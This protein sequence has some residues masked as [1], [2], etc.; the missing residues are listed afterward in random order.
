MEKRR[1]AFIGA[2]VAGVTSLIGSVAGGLMQ[3]NAAKRKAEQEQEQANR[4]NTFQQASILS[5]I[6][7]NQEFVDEYKNKITLKAGGKMKLNNKYEDRIEVDKR[8]ACGGRKRKACGGRKKAEFGINDAIT[9]VTNLANPLISQS[10]NN[11]NNV[12]TTNSASYA[13]RNGYYD[14]IKQYKCGGKKRK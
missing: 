6:A 10:F 1:K 2:A 9:S 7:N 3:K 5:E 12:V 11:D 13:G 14:R 8:F 4:Q